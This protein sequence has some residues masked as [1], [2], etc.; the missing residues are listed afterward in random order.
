V[1]LKPEWV[2][3]IQAGEVIVEEIDILERIWKSKARNNKVIKAVE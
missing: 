3:S 1:L 2:K